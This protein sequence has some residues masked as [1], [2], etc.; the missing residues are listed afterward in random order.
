MSQ[1]QKEHNRRLAEKQRL[2]LGLERREEDRARRDESKQR[3]RDAH[4]RANQQS[5][6]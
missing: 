6:Q 4:R 3:L 5:Q 2:E 1:D